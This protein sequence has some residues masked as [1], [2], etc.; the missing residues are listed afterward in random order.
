MLIQ[1]CAYLE[2]FVKM[3][4]TIF[5]DDMVG[6]VDRICGCKL[7]EIIMLNMRGHVANYIPE[8]VSLALTILFNAEPKV[9]SLRI[10][11][12]EVIVNAIYYN[13]HLA[14][15]VLQSKDL[16]NKLFS[17]WFSS[18]DSFTCV[19]EKKLCISA[20]CVF[21]TINDQNVP[22]SVQQG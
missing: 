10:H 13:A 1:N 9:K 2:A 22:V 20:I 17:M 16:T 6:G 11:L 7:A 15:H 4:R 21:L 3:I 12:M 14:L 18:I 5:K 8:F 19:Y